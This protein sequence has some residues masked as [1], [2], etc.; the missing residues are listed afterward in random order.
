M[1]WDPTY[2]IF[3]LP[4]LILALIAQAWVQGAYRRYLRLPNSQG[5]TG[6][7]A[8]ER[9]LRYAGLPVRLEGIRRELGDHYDPRGKV[10]RLSPNV[11]RTASVASVAIVAHE[12]GHAQQDAQAFLLLRLRSGLVAVV[13]FTSWLG[14][15]LFFI[16]WMLNLTS[17]AWLGVLFFAGAVVFALVTLPV[18]IDAS[19]R[20][21]RLLRETGILQTPEELR[22]AR[23]IL[24][25][26]ALTYVASLAQAIST[27]LYYVFLLRGGRR[28]R[29]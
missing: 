6:V 11:A 10:L 2:F 12:V 14:P 8:A 19:R 24:T 7:E 26:A 21:L 29:L 16:G 4:A 1:F 20:G 27:M 5:I 3:A 25:A 15:I 23:R 18:E 13:N 28:R 9:L 17:L 22:G